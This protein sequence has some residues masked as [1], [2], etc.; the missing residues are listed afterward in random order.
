ME[1]IIKNAAAVALS[2]VAKNLIEDVITRIVDEVGVESEDDLKLLKETDLVPLLKPIQARKLL[3]V[4]Q[5]GK[6]EFCDPITLE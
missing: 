3:A 5:K 4:L 2:S 6:I 1:D